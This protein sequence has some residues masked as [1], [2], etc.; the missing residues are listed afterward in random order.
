MNQTKKRK[1]EHL[2]ICANQNVEEGTTWLEHTKLVPDALTKLNPTQIDTSTTLLGK[3]LRAPL[4]IS[5]IT[6]GVEEAGKIN[7]DLA[8][9]AEQLGIGFGV[10]SQ[11]AMIEHSETWETFYVREQAP[12]TLVLGNVGAV[13]NYSAE[14]ILNAMQKIKADAMCM[15][16]NVAQELAQP[17]GDTS[18]EHCLEN[19]KAASKKLPVVAKETGCGINKQNALA[20]KDAGVKAIDVGGRGGTSWIKVEALR[21]GAGYAPIEWGIPTAAS[22]LETQVGVQLIATGGIR[23]GI[24]TAKA[25]A[26]GADSAGLALPVLRWYYKNGKEGVK[27][28]LEQMILELK[29]TMALTGSKDIKAL[30]NS[31]IV[32]NGP[33]FEWC[34]SRN[35]D[36]TRLGNR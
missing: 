26:L 32:V 11:R 18:F 34:Q 4:V 3:K 19:I 5:A 35:I 10:G 8:G 17:E 31:N 25:I 36:V 29:T 12:T 20:L 14:Q 21:K 2:D 33:L 28:G 30:K 1:L 13:N 7:R 23:S 9:I 22:I 16:L 24:Q 15:H 27:Q 6:G